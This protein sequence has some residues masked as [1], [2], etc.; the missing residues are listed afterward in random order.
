MEDTPKLLARDPNAKRYVYFIHAP[1]SGVVKIGSAADPEKRLRELQTG[2]PTPLRLIG[3]SACPS[4]T[5]EKELHQK[6]TAD[7]V[8]GEWFREGPV[9][10]MLRDWEYWSDPEDAG[11][12]DLPKTETTLDDVMFTPTY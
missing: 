2:C 5:A 7:R 8:R 3:R 10:E 4:D 11:R 6:F 12:F 9:I 1:E